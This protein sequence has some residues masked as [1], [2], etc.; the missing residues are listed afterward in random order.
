MPQKITLACVM[1]RFL[2]THPNYTPTLAD[3][4]ECMF[5]ISR[6]YMPLFW[7]IDGEIP[8]LRRAIDARDQE[9]AE[10]KRQ[11]ATKK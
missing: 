2:R 5:F 10:L 4:N 8:R 9:I 11:I 6:N 7:S 1:D 3:I